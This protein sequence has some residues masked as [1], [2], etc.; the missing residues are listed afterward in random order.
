MEML[1]LI[2]YECLTVFLPAVIAVRLFGLQYQ[3]RNDEKAGGYML[4]LLVF[5]VYLFGVF[6]V[7]GA[8]TIFHLKQYGLEYSTE[9][10]NLIPFSDTD[11]SHIGYALNV[12]LF[13]PLGFLV[14]CIWSNLNKVKYACIAGMA[15]SLLVELSQLLNIRATD[16]DDFI[17]NTAGAVMGFLV[18]RLYSRLVKRQVRTKAY[19]KYEIVIYIAATFLCRFLFFNE[20]GMAK[21][22]YGF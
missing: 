6:N 4:M 9:N 1:I 17:L 14:P 18:F 5:A 12:V 7:T 20:Y 3:K 22:L 10:I 19:G 15:L 13:V 11:F 2:G 8:G 21:L 16:I